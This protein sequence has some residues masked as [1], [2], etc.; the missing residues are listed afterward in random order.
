MQALLIQCLQAG[1]LGLLTGLFYPPARA[2]S[3]REVIEIAQPLSAY[4]GVYATHMRDEGDNVIE[5]LRETLEIGRAIHAPVIVSHHKCMGRANF[6]RSI[7]TLALLQ[8]AR[9]YQPIALDVYPYTAGL[10]VLNAELVAQSSRTLITW[11]DPWPQFCG[12]ELSEIAHELGCTPIEAIPRLLPAGALYFIMDEEDVT[13]IMQFSETMIGSDGLPGD[14][15]PH[16]RLWGTFP[17]VLGHY[18][19]ERAVLTLEDAVH[20]MTGLSA[21]R[22]GLNDRGGIKV[23]NYADLCI[24]DPR[25]V[26]DTATYERPTEPAVGIRRVFVNGQLALENGVPTGVRA[27]RCCDEVRQCDRGRSSKVIFA[28][29]SLRRYDNCHCSP[30]ACGV[31]MKI[32]II[33]GGLIGVT[34][35][36]FLRRRGYEVTVIDR[37]VGP[38]RGASFANGALLTPSMPEPW[39]APGCWRVLL[40]SLGRPDAAMRLRL[41]ALPALL[42]W[43][44]EFL[45]NSAAAAFERNVLSN[46]RLALYS[47]DVMQSLRQQ[48]NIEYGRAARGTLRIFRDRPTFDSACVAATRLALEGLRF[49]R[50]SMKETVELEPALEPIANQVTGA[51][52][53]ETDEVGDAHRFCVALADRAREQGV[54]VRFCTN[55][56]SLEMRAGQI[57]AVVGERERFVADK[58]IVAAGSYSSLLL[59]RVGVHI[60]VRPVKD[61][62]SRLMAIK[63]HRH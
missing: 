3:T 13:R 18:V 61:I 48:T 35:A 2:A 55:V 31:S 15:H 40:A 37:E 45:R 56:R 20:R 58:Y 44:V 39:N 41:R 47:L 34:T 27:G 36:Y 63:V 54:D 51:I 8:E 23:G 19:R 30:D 43:G 7:Q 46:L 38:G 5:S 32:L 21:S 59:R 4:Q 62:R 9:R 52:H 10:T 1:S 53:Y 24:F 29:G 12:R 60:P 22:F 14:Q 33:G 25:T 17:R 26:I 49:R 16:P 42:G 6:G 57:E 50:L 11:C 28:L